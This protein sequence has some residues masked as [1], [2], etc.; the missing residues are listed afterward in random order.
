MEMRMRSTIHGYRG[1]R[2]RHWLLGILIFLVIILIGISILEKA[3]SP[4][5]TAKERITKVAKQSNK[6]SSVSKF[7]RISRQNT[8]Y[9]TIGENK[10]HEQVGVI[11]RGKSN[12]L[13]TINIADGLSEKDVRKLVDKQFNPQKVTSIGLAIY[14]KVPVW[15][16]TFIDKDN[17]LNFITY[18]FSNGKQVQTIRH[19]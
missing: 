8:Y 1:K 18:Q 7:Y 4:I 14:E 2:L 9:S 17:N 19:L 12:K 5:D 3:Q 16:V 15:Q 13:T 6:L 10:K 11:A